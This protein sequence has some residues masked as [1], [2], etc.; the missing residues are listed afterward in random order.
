MSETI[1][2]IW[3]W[4]EANQGFLSLAALCFALLIALIEF[5]RAE[6]ATGLNTRQEIDAACEVLENARTDI[7]LAKAVCLETKNVS[8]SRVMV[9]D[10]LFRA[11][12]RLD[13]LGSRTNVALL[14][15]YIEEAKTAFGSMRVVPDSVDEAVASIDEI[16]VLLDQVRQ[17]FE[18][19][20]RRQRARRP[21]PSRANRT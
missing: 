7:R 16:D 19:I 15:S 21:T 11:S 14:A 18:L 17:R 8:Q 6:R 20:Q 9:A 12:K 1:A 13:V 3:P 2:P 5:I 10:T 4:A